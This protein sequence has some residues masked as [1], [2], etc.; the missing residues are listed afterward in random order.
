[1]YDALSLMLGI[2]FLTLST[3]VKTILGRSAIKKLVLQ[4][5]LLLFNVTQKASE[6][7]ST[8]FFLY[9]KIEYS[10]SLNLFYAC[11]SLQQF[12]GY[13]IVI[14]VNCVWVNVV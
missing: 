3:I 8:T 13:G 7:V 9:N 2:S 14:L 12:I 10:N 4:C 1:M 11:L 5:I 6:N